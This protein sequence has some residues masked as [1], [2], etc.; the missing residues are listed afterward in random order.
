M[1]RRDNSDIWLVFTIMLLLA[2]GII[3]IYSTS[4]IFADQKHNDS[5][6]FLKRHMLWIVIGLFL[7]FA[8]WRIDYH[9]LRRYSKLLAF[10]SVG[11][12]GLLY[13]PGL[14]RTA[15]GACRWIIFK[16]FS[17]QPSEVA[18]FALVVY[19]SDMFVRKQRWI[20]DFWKGL[21]PILLIVGV[22][23][24]LILKEPDLGS[25]IGIAMVV[26]VML[27]V[28]GARLRYLM[29]M[30][31]CALPFLYVFIFRVP[32]RRVRI[33]NFLHPWAD[34]QGV[35][36]QIVQSFLA[37]GSGGVFGVG[38]GQSRQKLFYLP[39]AHTDFIFSIIGEELGLIGT[40]L[41][42]GLFIAFVFLGIKI[43]RNAIDL[44]G[45]FLAIGIVSTISLQAVI[46]IGVVTGS[47]PTK[48]LPLPF[49]SFGGS[50]MVMYLVAIG[51]LLSI[52]RWTQNKIAS[53][54]SLA[55][56]ARIE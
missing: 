24:V 50:C 40:L 1:K 20:K 44:F 9:V 49:I 48:G 37:L 55:K 6:Y 47:F 4:A 12:L 43:A 3:M 5:L 51:V 18:K 34:P 16:G 15:G 45:F 27:F 19:L 39:A 53:G 17:F 26:C 54:S 36:F 42:V 22:I 38:L 11:L 10:A 52:H 14:G 25:V 31:L 23:M 29:V 35:G 30:G 28:A 13:V 2:I 7:M 46:N 56:D 8:V 33:M 21:I 32:Y 41:V